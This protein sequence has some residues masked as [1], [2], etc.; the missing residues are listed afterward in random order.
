LL[1]TDESN[2]C[3]KAAKTLFDAAGYDAGVHIELVKRIPYG[4]GLGGGSA[5]AAATL[6]ALHRI[7]D[8]Q[9]DDSALHS[10]A[11]SIGADVPYFL[12][13]GS[14]YAKGKGDVLSYFDLVLPYWILIVHPGVK[15]S[16]P[17]AYQNF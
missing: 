11:A 12:S 7:F 17:W 1:P 3:V 13:G 2:L 16:T 5:D 14:A 6:T 8:L 10:I 4:A 9:L 15:V